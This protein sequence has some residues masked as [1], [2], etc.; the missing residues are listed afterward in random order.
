MV[1]HSIAWHND[2]FDILWYA[3]QWPHD[4]NS[5]TVNGEVLAYTNNLPLIIRLKS[6]NWPKT[7]Q[8]VDFHYEYDFSN[9]DRFYPVNIWA[10]L[11]LIRDDQVQGVTF[12]VPEIEFGNATNLS[13]SG[14]QASNFL[15]SKSIYSCT[16]SL[17]LQIK[18]RF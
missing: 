4:T 8:W 6:T 3:S 9:K 18:A 7:Y 10:N 12:Q 16:C 14:Y 11:V 13:E 1:P 17:F 2:Q 15:P 5:Y